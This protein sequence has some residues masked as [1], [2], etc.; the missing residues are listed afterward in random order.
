MRPPAEPWRILDN[1]RQLRR[2][3]ADATRTLQRGRV[4]RSAA[5]AVPA[6]CTTTPASIL[7]QRAP[8]SCRRLSRPDR[9]RLLALDLA[10]SGRK[11]TS[12]RGSAGERK[13]KCGDRDGHRK[14]ARTQN[15]G[16]G[17]AALSDGLRED[18]PLV[19]LSGLPH[20]DRPSNEGWIMIP[21]HELNQ[22]SEVRDAVAR[23]C[24]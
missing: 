14:T 5:S 4:L 12:N 17:Q 9:R 10:V 11:P 21:A 7:L 1:G 20:W 3:L 16:R 6:W 23:Q 19:R 15:L 24:V 13:R 22:I 8:G 2:F 18:P